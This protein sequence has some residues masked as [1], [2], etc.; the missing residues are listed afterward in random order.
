MCSISGLTRKNVFNFKKFDSEESSFKATE[1][2]IEVMRKQNGISSYI[3]NGNEFLY[4]K[5]FKTAVL[6][7][8]AAKFREPSFESKKNKRAKNPFDIGNRLISTS[9]AKI[10][11]SHFL[12][13]K[14]YKYYYI[15]VPIGGWLH[16]ACIFF[17]KSD[18]FIH[19]VFY[20]PNYSDVT[21]GVESSKIGNEL[22]RS[23]KGRLNFIQAYHSPTGN[24]ENACSAFTWM[25]IFNHV[26][27]GFIPFDNINIGLESYNALATDHSYKKY[28]RKTLLKHFLVWINLDSRLRDNLDEKD[29]LDIEKK[30][31]NV[32]SSHFSEI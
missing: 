19:A 28:R 8:C 4:N 13:H 10:E 22:L 30:I 20:N 26:C 25:E 17:K 21:E 5:L 6:L 23:F 9:K 18:K 27:Q 14:L 11:I 32:I 12:N 2:I 31:A 29:L 24:V 3:H 15:V 1:D 16:E 7:K